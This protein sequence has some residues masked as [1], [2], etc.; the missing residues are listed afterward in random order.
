MGGSKG[1]EGRRLRGEAGRVRPVYRRIP[2]LSK[3]T[4]AKDKRQFFNGLIMQP[5]QTGE[6]QI[7]NPGGYGT[8]WL[9]KGYL[10]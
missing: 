10:V 3:T 6:D 7:F 9:F 4:G 2:I 1:R 8:P 5:V